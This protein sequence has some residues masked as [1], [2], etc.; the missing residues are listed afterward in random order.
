M[1][2]EC[3]KQVSQ[4]LGNTPAVTRA[5]YI[6]PALIQTY[7]DG[8]LAD[9]LAGAARPEGPQGLEPEE[10]A[11]LRLLDGILDPRAS[12]PQRSA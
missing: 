8:S 9:A 1:I 10:A 11:V 2:R 5:C 6:H 7:L 12:R 4:R 3:V